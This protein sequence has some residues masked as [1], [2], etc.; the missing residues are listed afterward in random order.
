MSVSVG[1]GGVIDQLWVAL[2]IKPDSTG[3]RQIKQEV[4]EAKSSL[5]SIGGAVKAFVA[6]FA[7]HEVAGIGSEFEQFGIQI[8]GFLNAMGYS[9]NFN[10]ALQQSNDIIK[11]IVTSSAKLPGQAS[12]YIDTFRMGI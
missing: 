5:I 11:E 7:I 2:G 3:F 4:D 6:G 1:A 12:E 9:S 10:N 8:A